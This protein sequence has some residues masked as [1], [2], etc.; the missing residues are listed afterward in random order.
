MTP[1]PAS[2]AA[3]EP[4]PAYVSQ[5]AGTTRSP[6]SAKTPTGAPRR[7]RTPTASPPSTPSSEITE[8]MVPAAAAER[9]CCSMRSVGRSTITGMV[10]DAVR[11]KDA[12]STA[13]HVSSLARG[14]GP[15]AAC[16]P[17]LRGSRTQT[18]SAITNVRPAISPIQ[19]RQPR[20][21][22]TAP[23][24]SVLAPM[25]TGTN[26]AQID[27]AAPRSRS[28]ARR[29]ISAGQEM[30]TRRYPM[31]SRP[32]TASN[33][34]KSPAVTLTAL[35]AAIR[36]SPTTSDLSAPKRRTR[37][38][39]GRPAT[40]PTPTTAEITQPSCDSDSPN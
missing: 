26:V 6:N 16:H 32:R 33:Q 10:T 23:P 4:P 30:V 22:P 1:A 27:R 28:W 14:T 35:A 12:P 3:S 20:T 25:P 34:A 17:D 15:A 7:S 21:E 2:A 19:P 13:G 40:A 39:A 24:A 8:V 31:P 36:V 29:R 38:P 5:A 18:A 37:Y 11:Q 9:P